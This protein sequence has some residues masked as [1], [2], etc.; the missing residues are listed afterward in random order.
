MRLFTGARSMRIGKEARRHERGTGRKHGPYD[1]MGMG[2][3][4]I[5][6]AQELSEMQAAAVEARFEGRGLCAGSRDLPTSMGVKEE[7]TRRSWGHTDR[8]RF[9]SR[10][11][12]AALFP[13]T[14]TPGPGMYENVSTATAFANRGGERGDPFRSRCDMATLSSTRGRRRPCTAMG[15]T[16]S[17]V[18]ASAT[19]ARGRRPPASGASD[20]QQQVHSILGAP[21][22][23]RQPHLVRPATSGHCSPRAAM[24]K[25][26]V[27][28]EQYLGPRARR[29]MQ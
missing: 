18:C 12:R 26:V 24:I 17:T 28:L 5:S 20:R 10:S 25:Q 19:S 27:A 6:V 9:V 1:V 15:I 29:L 4:D 22:S 21:S 2:G 16:R 8:G 13:T 3:I 14:E 23:R 11:P 7:R